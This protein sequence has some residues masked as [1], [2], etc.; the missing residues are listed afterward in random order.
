MTFVAVLDFT[1]GKMRRRVRVGN[2]PAGLVRQR[3]LIAMTAEACCRG[4]RQRRRLFVM[5]LRTFQSGGAMYGDQERPISGMQCATPA[6]RCG[7][8]D[9]NH[10]RYPDHL[11]FLR[12]KLNGMRWLSDINP[13]PSALICDGISFVRLASQMQRDAL[14]TSDVD[15]HQRQGSN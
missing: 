2:C 11:H 6:R 14:M 5:T 8:R 10:H 7:A 12:I 9:E 4:R 13:P 1:G 15:L 3:L